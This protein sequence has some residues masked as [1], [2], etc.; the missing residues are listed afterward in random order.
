MMPIGVTC[1]SETGVSEASIKKFNDGE[2]N[3]DPELKCYMNCL[4]REL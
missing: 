1:K 2:N 3:E 4:F